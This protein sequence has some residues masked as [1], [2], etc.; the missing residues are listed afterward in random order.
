MFRLEKVTFGAERFT[1]HL[2]ALL[3]RQTAEGDFS[4]FEQVFL[5]SATIIIIYYTMLWPDS[6]QS[7][8]EV[9]THVL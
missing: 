6:L 1:E 2:C 7:T 8:L 4:A 9:N 3:P 5:L